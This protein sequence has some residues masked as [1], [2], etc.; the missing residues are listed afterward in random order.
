M[1]ESGA[2]KFPAQLQETS[3]P[4]LHPDQDEKLR[5]SA[6]TQ[7]G[8]E[9]ERIPYLNLPVMQL[10][11]ELFGSRR[12][13]TRE[14]YER[15]VGHYAGPVS[16]RTICRRD[17]RE[18]YEP[19]VGQYAGPVLICTIRQSDTRASHRASRRA[20]LDSN[21]TPRRHERAVGHTA[22]PASNHPPSRCAHRAV[23]RA[24]CRASRCRGAAYDPALKSPP[25]IP[26]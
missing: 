20:R 26:N 8:L 25:Q 22:R 21:P 3:S 24:I 18:R 6:H 13:D 23:H 16:I 17:T 2:G 15:A 9:C 1:Y 12:S 4:Y 19:A 11:R 10:S 5:A 14:R 7:K